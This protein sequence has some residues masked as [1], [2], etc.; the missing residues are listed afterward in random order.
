MLLVGTFIVF[1]MIVFKRLQHYGWRKRNYG[2]ENEIIVPSK[3][4]LNERLNYSRKVR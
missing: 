4:D 2:D 3:E 1:V